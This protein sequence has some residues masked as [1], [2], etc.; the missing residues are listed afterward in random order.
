MNLELMQVGFSAVVVSEKGRVT[1]CE[2]LDWGDG[3]ACGPFVQQLAQ[4]IE[5]SLDPHRYL[6][7]MARFIT[8]T[9]REKPWSQVPGILASKGLSWS[10]RGW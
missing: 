7:G 10:I 5:R 1:S 8:Q 3:T 4:L 6:F 2:N 9:A